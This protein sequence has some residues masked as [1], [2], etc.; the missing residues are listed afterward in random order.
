MRVQFSAT[1]QESCVHR[2]NQVGIS[3]TEKDGAESIP[4]PSVR[5]LSVAFDREPFGK[6][7]LH[8]PMDRAP[9]AAI[10]DGRIGTFRRDLFTGGTV[11]GIWVA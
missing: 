10:A 2:Q 3:G 9:Y 8:L 11:S 4:P 1:F 6:R 7:A 5:L